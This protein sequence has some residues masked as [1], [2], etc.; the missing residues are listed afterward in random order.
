MVGKYLRI[1]LGNKYT[2]EINDCANE[3]LNKG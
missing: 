1:K 3:V 2:K